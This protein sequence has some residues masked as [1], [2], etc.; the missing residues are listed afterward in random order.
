VAHIRRIAP[1]PGA[2]VPAPELPRAGRDL[3]VPGPVGPGDRHRIR[4][5]EDL[6]ATVTGGYCEPRN[7][8]SLNP[9]GSQGREDQGV[10]KMIYTPNIEELLASGYSPDCRTGPVTTP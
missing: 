1:R 3:S 4:V 7:I 5:R 6:D 2:A 10:T 8:I 9:V